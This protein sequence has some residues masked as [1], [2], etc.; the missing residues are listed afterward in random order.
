[1]NATV[2]GDGALPAPDA[3]N[4]PAP[5]RLPSVPRLRAEVII[6]LGLSLGK[7]AIYAIMRLIERYLA[8]PAIA[9]QSTTLNASK[10]SINYVDLTYQI[11]SI[12]FALVPVAL[13]LYLLSAHGKSWKAQLGLGG[14]AGRWGRDL[15]TGAVLAAIIGLPGLGVYAVGRAIGQSVRINTNGLPDEWWASVILL[16]SAAVA[17]LL[18]E[19]IVVGY[20]MTRLRQ[21][22]WSIPLAILAS[23]V[24]RGSYHLYQGW[25]M[26]LGNVAMGVVF[27][28]YFVRTGRVGPLI[29]AHWILDTVS[30]VGPELVPASWIDA[31][32]GG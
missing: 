13:A 30:F 25:P 23:A 15:A 14:R 32:N 21:L 22:R 29:A 10:S 4:A 7:S 18:E 26:A 9:S 8:E 31:L 6:V 27:A 5:T 24:L 19:V 16:A 1:M 28:L 3:A 2:A 12:I 20:L 17:G 11:L